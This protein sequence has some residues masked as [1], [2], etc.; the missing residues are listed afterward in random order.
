M[1]NENLRILFKQNLSFSY[2]LQT[3]QSIYGEKNKPINSFAFWSRELYLELGDKSNHEGNG[4]TNSRIN[5]VI[6]GKINVLKRHG[7]MH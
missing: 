4:A 3:I 7:Q 5:F 6:T 2:D 1:A